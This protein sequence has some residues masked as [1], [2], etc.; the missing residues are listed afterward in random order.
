VVVDPFKA[1][2]PNAPVLRTDKKDKKDNRIFH[3]EAGDRAAT[4]KAFAEAEVTVKQDLYIPR[5]MSRRSRHAGCI[6]TS[7]G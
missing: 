1:L 4:E 7:T 5:S 3:W 2:E 6:A